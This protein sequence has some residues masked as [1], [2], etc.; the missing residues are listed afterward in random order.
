MMMMM[1]ISI[2]SQATRAIDGV[3]HATHGLLADVPRTYAR[4]AGVRLHD[5]VLLDATTS[6][7][8]VV[9]SGATLP[10]SVG[11]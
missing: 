7:V 6:S 2:C 9:G 1:M 4:L 10:V 11:L 5:G 8:H 3:E